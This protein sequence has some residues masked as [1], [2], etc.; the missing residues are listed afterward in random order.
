MY[1]KQQSNFNF[2]WGF[3][4]ISISFDVMTDNWLLGN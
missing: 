2:F 3:V 4:A 1:D